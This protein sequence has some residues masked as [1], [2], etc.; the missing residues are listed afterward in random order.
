M[1]SLVFWDTSAFLALAN[2]RDS[3]HQRAV[4]VSQNLSTNRSKMIT[5]DAVLIEVANSLSKINFRPIAQQII[6]SIF[7]SEKLE[8]AQVIHVD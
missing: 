7:E 3:L 6:Q 2:S 5:T 4:R 8:Q 1:S